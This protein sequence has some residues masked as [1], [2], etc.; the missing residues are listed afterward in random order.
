MGISEDFLADTKKVK[1]ALYCTPLSRLLQLI[2]FTF[3][4]RQPAGRALFKIKYIVL[5]IILSSN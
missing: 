3:K 4:T 2:H 5:Q 1:I